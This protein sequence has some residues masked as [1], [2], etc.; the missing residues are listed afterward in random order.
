MYV[1]ITRPRRRLYMSFAQTRMLHGQT[2]YN[3]RSRFFEEIPEG[4]LKWLSPRFAT[5][6]RYAEPSYQKSTIRQRTPGGGSGAPGWRIG[7]T[8][9]HAKF[10]VD[11]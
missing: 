7:Q 9:T 6:P 2:R 11:R 10:G 4:L 5:P 1:A 3:I 8:V